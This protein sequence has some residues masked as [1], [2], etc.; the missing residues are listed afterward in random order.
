MYPI[1]SF[2]LARPLQEQNI[3]PISHI[4]QP[5]SNSESAS[6]P[7]TFPSTETSSK[8]ASPAA[9]LATNLTSSKS[10]HYL[11]PKN[12]A[13][14]VEGVASV[15]SGPEML[16][17][18]DGTDD[19]V[20][21]QTNIAFLDPMTPPTQ[22]PGKGDYYE[23]MQ[24]SLEEGPSGV[25]KTSCSPSVLASKKQV[26]I[27]SRR[28]SRGGRRSSRVRRTNSICLKESGDQL[29]NT[30]TLLRR[31]KKEGG[32]EQISCEPVSVTRIRN[33]Y[34]TFLEQSLKTMILLPSEKKLGRR[35]KNLPPPPPDSYLTESE[36]MELEAILNENM[37]NMERIRHMLQFM[38]H[39]EEEG[40]VLC[41][42]THSGIDVEMNEDDDSSLPG[43][44]SDHIQ[45]LEGPELLTAQ[46]LVLWV[47]RLLFTL[48][49]VRKD[50]A[51]SLATDA[52]IM[53]ARY[54]SRIPTGILAQ[55]QKQDSSPCDS[56]IIELID[57]RNTLQKRHSYLQVDVCH[58]TNS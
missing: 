39:L 21:K 12:V 25:M 24:A 1:Q 50:L 55:I 10:V 54:Y 16:D 32:G 6:Y 58:F 37:K 3:K 28:G 44:C 57:L 46:S 42:A 56:L 14:L 35:S 4:D 30:I 11:E 31:K 18:S 2:N 47:M 40:R 34:K 29:L 36:S 45:L 48:S 8:T 43:G 53:G 22:P 33:D 5:P 26:R 38:K 41:A 27:Q 7:T 15:Y 17:I 20:I 13:A 51:N 49:Y 9:P 23:R 52:K 19:D